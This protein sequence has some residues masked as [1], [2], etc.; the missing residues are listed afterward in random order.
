M[1]TKSPPSA[2]ESY[3]RLPPETSLILLTSTLG[4]SVNW[5]TARFIGS[6]LQNLQAS[7]SSEGSEGDGGKDVAVLVVSWMRDLKFWQDE[8]R[9][10]AGIDISKPLYAKR[11]GFVDRLN[12][13]PST[14]T[15]LQ[16]TQSRISSAISK[17]CTSTSSSEET[18]DGPKILLI[19]DQPDLVLATGHPT[20][21]SQ[22][23]S[24]FLL[25]LRSLPQIHSTYLS[26]SADL[27]L[28]TAASSELSPS[29]TSPL[30]TESA[31]FVVTQAHASRVIFSVRELETGAAKDVSGVLRITRG[32]DY[33]AVGGDDDDG[34]E[35]GD[36]VKEVELLYLLQ[37]DGGLKVF[38]RGE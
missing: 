11:F 30:E 18:Q 34:D 33:F 37:R 9:R 3:L 19:L 38:Q 22:D 27:P 14:S 1:T 29:R 31:A 36:E 16:E 4:C 8:V 7:A 17:L 25:N 5:L 23:L 35:D 10:V 2:L 26:L 24:T 6:A 15:N 21:T 12:T 32:G 13:P 28:I 20:L